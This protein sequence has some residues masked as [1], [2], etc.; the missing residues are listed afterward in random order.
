VILPFIHPLDV[1]GTT[2]KPPSNVA[3]G[4]RIG[5]SCPGFNCKKLRSMP[6]ITSKTIDQPRQFT[7]K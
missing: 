2:S 4:A 6:A 3:I 5:A 1:G 7:M